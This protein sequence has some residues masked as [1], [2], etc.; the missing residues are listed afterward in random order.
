MDKG[1]SITLVNGKIVKSVK[2]VKKGDS[3]IT[4][5]SDGQVVSEVI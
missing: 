3:V 2:D 4:K 1:Y 5:L